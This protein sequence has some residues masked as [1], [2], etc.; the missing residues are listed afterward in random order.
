MQIWNSTISLCNDVSLPLSSWLLKIGAYL[1]QAHSR[2][3]GLNRDG[4][5]LTE[6]GGGGLFNSETAMVSVLHKGLENK[7]DK[8]RYKKVEDQKQIR[9]SSW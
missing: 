9:T 7:V 4:G 6:T 1:F 5:G 3:G 2:G 8:L